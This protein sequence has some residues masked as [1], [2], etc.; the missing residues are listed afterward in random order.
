[1]LDKLSGYAY[2]I[3][4]TM[5]KLK[6]RTLLGFISY[7]RCILDYQ[8]KVANHPSTGFFQLMALAIL[9]QIFC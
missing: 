8:L 2:C 9:R 4:G 7:T 1:M 6:G 3:A 5:E